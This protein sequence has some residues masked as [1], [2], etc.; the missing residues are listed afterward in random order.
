M[1]DLSHAN[2]VMHHQASEIFG[3][4]YVRKIIFKHYYN[5][6]CLQLLIRAHVGLLNSFLSQGIVIKFTLK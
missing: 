2:L 1:D 5:N 4:A 3:V 6:Q